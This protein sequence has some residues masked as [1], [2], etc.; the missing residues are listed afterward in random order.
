[1]F[2]GA[3]TFSQDLSKW[4][5]SAVTNMQA[6]FAYVSKFNQDLSKWVVAAVIDMAYMFS[7]AA[8]FDQD[9][10]DWDVSACYPRRT[11]YPLS[12]GPSIQNHRITK[13]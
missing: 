12:D 13:T 1:M 10:S 6:M 2:S 5:V 8:T 9:L 11:F 4:D 7:G 3:S